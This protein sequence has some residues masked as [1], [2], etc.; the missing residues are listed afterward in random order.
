MNLRVLVIKL[1]ALFYHLHRH[2]YNVAAYK[3][4]AIFPTPS[5]SNWIVHEPVLEALAERGHQII[6]LSPYSMQLQTTWNG[7]VT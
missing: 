7:N 3:F 2:Q 5:R 4:L 1:F 6:V